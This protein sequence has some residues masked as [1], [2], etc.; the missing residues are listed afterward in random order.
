M[1]HSDNRAVRREESRQ[2]RQIHGGA[3]GYF[4][5][6]L[7][8]R[9]SRV[10]IPSRSLRE[11]VFRTVYGRKYLALDETE[12]DRPLSDFRSFNELFTRGVRAECRPIERLG[13]RLVCP[14][15]GIVQDIGAL[16]GDTL[17]TVKNIAYPI[18]ALFPGMDNSALIGGQFAILFLS[19]ADCHRVFAPDAGVIRAIAHIPGRRLLVHPPYQRP[20]FPVFT[21]NERLVIRVSTER[22]EYA[23]AM[24]AGWGVG[25]ITH[26][27]GTLTS[28]T[29]ARLS[30]HKVTRADNPSDGQVERGQW[31]ATFELGSTVVLVAARSM[32]ATPLVAA[33]QRVA[34]GQPIFDT[35]PPHE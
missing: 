23:L 20:E 3:W 25:H 19:P 10:P 34:Y 16:R 7:G 14:C 12:L 8:V 22:G 30:H 5:A 21:L 35:D 17:L 18:D 15:D 29:H 32:N 26:P 13:D 2:A 28:W 31:I 6:S 24:V 27:P 1:T 9:L 33:G 4:L 11:R